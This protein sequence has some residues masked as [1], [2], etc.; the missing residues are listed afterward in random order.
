MT[1]A[2]DLA[3]AFIRHSTKIICSMPHIRSRITASSKN[4]REPGQPPKCTKLFP[5][6]AGRASHG[7]AKANRC[8]RG[9]ATDAFTGLE[10]CLVQHEQP[11]QAAADGTLIVQKWPIS[12]E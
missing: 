11:V 10:A 9:F 3:T 6:T 7:S 4:L 12:V 2:N 5:E 1:A 8:D